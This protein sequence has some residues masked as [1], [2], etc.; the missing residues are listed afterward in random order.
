MD[1]SQ[2][3]TELVQFTGVEAQIQ[4]NGSL[5]Q[6]IQ[7][8]QGNAVMQSTQLVGK[9]VQVDSKQLTLQNGQA[10]VS[11]TAPT[12]GTAQ[13]A[14]TTAAGVPVYTSTIDNTQ[15]ANTW[16][17]NGQGGNGVTEPDGAYT[18]SVQQVGAGGT[19]TS[20][21]FTVGGTVT[22]VQQQGGTV[23]IELGQ[24]SVGVGSLASV[25]N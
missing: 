6:L 4:S 22:G 14:V 1:S 16:K 24:L 18:V 20:L 25:Q 17:W 13:I 19:T 15:G 8:A 7:L 11:F 5:T 3:T 23:E 21:P 2:F 12:A 9:Q 10:S